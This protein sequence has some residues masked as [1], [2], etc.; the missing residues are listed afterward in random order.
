[1]RFEDDILQKMFG[2]GSNTT[3]QRNV[4][5]DEINDRNG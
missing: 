5:Q 4:I 1:M 3:T 2:E